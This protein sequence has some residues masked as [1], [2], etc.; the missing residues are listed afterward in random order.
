MNTRQL[1]LGLSILVPA[2]CGAKPHSP[3]THEIID[4]PTEICECKVLQTK[5]ILGHSDDDTD[6]SPIDEICSSVGY[7]VEHGLLFVWAN[8]TEGLFFGF[9][10]PKDLYNYKN[11]L[12][13]AFKDLRQKLDR[14]PGALRFKTWGS[15]RKQ[16]E[17]LNW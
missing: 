10:L 3:F 17:K 4:I 9:S 5:I 13:E 16:P 1:L 15:F 2:V 7:R 8:T 12:P 11:E 6:F 14:Y